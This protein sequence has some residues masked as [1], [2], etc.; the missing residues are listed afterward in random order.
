MNIK[1]KN[2][3]FLVVLWTRMT[4]NWYSLL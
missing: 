1:S 4:C 2:Q 3:W